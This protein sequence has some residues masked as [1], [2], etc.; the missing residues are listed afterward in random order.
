VDASQYV[1]T[2][3]DGF[4]VESN[5]PDQAQP[6][7]SSEPV[8]SKSAPKEASEPADDSENTDS[9]ERD[10]RGRWRSKGQPQAEATDDETPDAEP[11]KPA[12]PRDDPQA[13]V[14]QVI[15]RQ[16]EAERRAE[17]AERRATEL[18]A[19]LRSGEPRE[20]QEPA[21]EPAAA[22]FPRFEQWIAQNTNA[23]HD[24][25]LD[26]RDDWR[27]GMREQQT[28][29]RVQQHEAQRARHQVASTFKAQIDSAI[30]DDPQ[31]L[32]GISH[33]VLSVPTFEALRQGE[34]PTPMHFLGEELLR[35]GA[36]TDLMR[37]WTANP[38]KFQRFATLPPREIT[39]QIAIDE[40]HARPDAAPVA[41]TAPAPSLSQAKPPV[42]RVTGSPHASGDEPPGDDA[43]FDTHARYW[44]A[45]D[46][47]ARPGR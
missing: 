21:R 10:E 11:K 1:T 31:F 34:R 9:G 17:Q 41:R 20:A 15:A 32:A 13:R 30:A 45:K 2:A 42:K 3:A 40:V 6:V 37:Y 35:S 27:D 36:S 12:K 4:E 5:A 19:R 47:K 8:Q 43:D 24:D 18:E 25:Y 44:N 7:E 28:Q 22:R 23:S 39:R 26:A 14:Q 38:E 29:Q 46:R 16:R 33:D